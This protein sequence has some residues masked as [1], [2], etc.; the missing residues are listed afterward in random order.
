MSA[1]TQRKAE[2][3]AQ[4]K[5][6]RITEDE[7]KELRRLNTAMVEAQEDANDAQREMTDCQVR[8]NYFAIGL[9][10]KYGTVQIN[11]DTGIMT[12]TPPPQG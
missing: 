1:R 2:R 10:E 11:T 7:L 6:K 4:R 8:L 3:A 9:R 5:P 12:P